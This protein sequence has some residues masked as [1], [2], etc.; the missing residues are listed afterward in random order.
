MPWSLGLG[1]S[2][3]SVPAVGEQGTFLPSW[4]ILET[5]P[6][7][8]KV[9]S[10]HPPNCYEYS[11]VWDEWYHLMKM[12]IFL[13]S[14]A[15]SDFSCPEKYIFILESTRGLACWG[16]CPALPPSLESRAVLLSPAVRKSAPLDTL[17]AGDSPETIP[18]SQAQGGRA[19][20]TLVLHI[21]SEQERSC[22]CFPAQA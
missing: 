16:P 4:C 9:P 11:W 14:S 5:I 10:L 19:R 7:T 18:P 17:G 15:I 2:N 6:S 20:Q 12:T 8:I 22:C 3:T 1:S 21:P 13:F